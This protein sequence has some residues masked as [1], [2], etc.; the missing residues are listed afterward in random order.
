V[1]EG[2]VL[3]APWYVRERRGTGLRDPR[4]LRPV[5]QMYDR[6]DFVD[7]LLADPGHSLAYGL[8]DRY[9]YPRAK[10]PTGAG[11]G[12]GRFLTH[13]LVHTRM[14]KLYQ[15][16][17][18][19]FYVVVV[20]VFCDAPGLPRAGSHRD[21]SVS[22]VVRRRLTSLQ[23]TPAEQRRLARA[24]LVELAGSG[25]S[26]P[27][28]LDIGDVLFAEEAE[29][30]R[31]DQDHAPLIE[32]LQATV[33]EEGW[34]TRPGA[35][36]TATPAGEGGPLPMADEE[37]LPMFRLP[38]RPDCPPDRTRSLWFGLVPTYSSDHWTAP[39]G[40]V[41]PKLDDRSIYAIRC[42]VTQPPG[43]GH[44]HCPPKRFVSVPTRPFKLA[45]PYDPDG[46]KNRTISVTAPDL[47]R[48]AA[49]AG[50]P[51]GP[52]G[53]QITTPPGSGLGP[54]D[55][56]SIPGAGLGSPG[57]GSICTFAFELFFIVAFFLFLLF[58]PIVVLVFQLWWML[59]LRFCLPPS[60]SFSALATFFA[61]HNLDDLDIQVGDTPA[62]IDEK[63]TLRGKLDEVLGIDD[64]AT[65][66]RASG[67]DFDND[68]GLVGDLVAA[69]TPPDDPPGLPDPD[70]L[71]TPPDPLCAAGP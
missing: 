12:I 35:G 37:E 18:N 46:T 57:G 53:L 40:T 31:F 48:L 69:I 41:Q 17:H 65:H 14:R 20:E 58:L 39:D 64:A 49:T 38:P 68:P 32:A 33:H 62:E 16:S 4:S 42:V 26:G 63:N 19:R 43:P 60:L 52:G 25:P 21:I 30:Q 61:T 22:M 13:E 59:A 10:A 36:W 51:R 6:T 56:K 47:R 28:D 50:K 3:R 5:V 9:S 1:S 44:E 15:P 55:F 23:G 34:V 54:V 2:F 70:Y 27:V 11:T 8:E 71:V 7:Q 29:R 67:S 66:L 45:A 24:L